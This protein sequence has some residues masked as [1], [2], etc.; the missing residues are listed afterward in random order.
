M[1]LLDCEDQLP[2]AEEDDDQ[3]DDEVDYEHV[4]D[5]GLVVDLGLECVVVDPTRAL[6]ALRDIPE[7]RVREG[8]GSSV[9]PHL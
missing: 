8:G 5:K 7:H 3:R 2:I 1:Y 6:H 4:D 9:R